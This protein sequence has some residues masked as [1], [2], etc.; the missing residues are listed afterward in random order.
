MPAKMSTAMIL[1]DKAMEL[2]VGF[3]INK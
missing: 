3:A 1:F 2:T